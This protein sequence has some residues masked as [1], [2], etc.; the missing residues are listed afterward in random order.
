MLEVENIF[1]FIACFCSLKTCLAFFDDTFEAQYNSL[2]PNGHFNFSHNFF[3]VGIF[4]IVSALK[5]NFS[6]DSVY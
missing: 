6:F 3:V 5:N 4:V 1:L 2:R